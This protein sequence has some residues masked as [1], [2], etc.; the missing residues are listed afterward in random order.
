MKVLKPFKIATEHLAGET[1]PTISAVDPLLTEIKKR[2]AEDSNDSNTIAVFKKAL[3]DDVNSRYRDPDLQ[4][5]LNKA[6]FLDPRFKSLAHLS[7]SQQEEIKYVMLFY[8]S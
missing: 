2:V 5:L 7:S 1:Y 6:S 3:R 4:M 8:K